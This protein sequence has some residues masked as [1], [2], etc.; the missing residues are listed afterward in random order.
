MVLA[1]N[2]AK[3]LSSVNHTTK[4]IHHH[5]INKSAGTDMNIVLVKPPS[6]IIHCI[7]NL[8]ENLIVL[9]C[10]LNF[11]KIQSFTYR[12][13]NNIIKKIFRLIYFK[14]IEKWLSQ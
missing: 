13:R 11:K 8:S 10:L 7:A 2:K 14:C 9:G 5:H 6:I 1:G 3:R 4:K 12:V